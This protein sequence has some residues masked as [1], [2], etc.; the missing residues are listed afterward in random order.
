MSLASSRVLFR[1]SLAVWLERCEAMDPVAL[2]VL[3]AGLYT[4]A[5]AR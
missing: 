1:C 4:S 2:Q 5:V 3:E